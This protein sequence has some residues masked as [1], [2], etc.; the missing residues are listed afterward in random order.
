MDTTEKE[1][2]TNVTRFLEA[3]L[4]SDPDHREQLAV[5][6][7]SDKAKEMIDVSL[8]HVQV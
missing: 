4:S 1:A 2:I 8:T 5:L 3:E 6:V 7:A